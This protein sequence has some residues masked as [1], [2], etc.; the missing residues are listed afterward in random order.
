MKVVT[1]FLGGC[2]WWA[3]WG[4][5]RADN[6][7]WVA[8]VGASLQQNLLGWKCRMGK[9]GLK[10]TLQGLNWCLG[11]GAWAQFGSRPDLP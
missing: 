3:L 5:L 11:V 1:L 2:A 4:F 10:L 6:L 7:V 9:G 8:D